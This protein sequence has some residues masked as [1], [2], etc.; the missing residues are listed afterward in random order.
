VSRPT[1][2]NAIAMLVNDGLL[3]REPNKPATSVVGMDA[4][5]QLHTTPGGRSHVN[6]GLGQYT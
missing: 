1:A 2:K 3:W 6:T 5:R 4:V